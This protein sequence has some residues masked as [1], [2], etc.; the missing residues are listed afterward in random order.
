MGMDPGAVQELV[1]EV[2]SLQRAVRIA[3]AKAMSY[4]SLGL[5]HEGVL[6]LV[7]QYDGCRAI[8]LAAHLGVG[9]S[10][11]SRQLGELEDLGLVRRRTSQSDKRAHLLALT[12]AGTAHMAEIQEARARLLGDALTNWDE[13]DVANAID[14]LSRLGDALRAPAPPPAD[15]AP[16][17][18]DAHSHQLAGHSV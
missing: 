17:I 1:R 11:L 7:A 3:D 10:S 12:E 18:I 2:Y 4:G 8:D 14:V 16:Q 9:A 13:T 6:M 15:T 5:A